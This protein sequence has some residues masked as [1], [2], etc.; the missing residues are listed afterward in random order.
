V[1]Q[2]IAIIHVRFGRGG[3]VLMID[4]CPKWASEQQ[5]FELLSYA[6]FDCYQALANGR[7]VFRIDRNELEALKVRH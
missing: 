7:G 3:T 6:T 1:L 5:W 2:G 4:E